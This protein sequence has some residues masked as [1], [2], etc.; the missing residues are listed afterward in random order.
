MPS[1]SHIV[2]SETHRRAALVIYDNGTVETDLNQLIYTNGSVI[3]VE[4]E[5]PAGLESCPETSPLL[6]KFS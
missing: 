4:L 1:D 3:K 6:G 2:T 5:E